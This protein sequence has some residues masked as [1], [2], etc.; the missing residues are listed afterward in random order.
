MQS[1]VLA[2][3]R[4]PMLV[5]GAGGTGKSAVLRERFARLVEGG[6]DPERVALVVGS[7]RARAEASRA[8]LERLRRSLPGLR[9]QTIHGLAFHVV[10]ARYGELGYAAPPRILSASDQFAKVRELLAGEDPGQW[11]AYG[12]MLSM[13][14]FAD[15]VRQF[16]SRAQEALR[17]P[18]EIEAGAGSAGLSG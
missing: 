10:N 14:G 13:R 11:P 1:R 2:H 17:T 5:A 4:G 6:A 8:L 15:Q 3:E 7:K 18:D 12:S 9:V 16:L